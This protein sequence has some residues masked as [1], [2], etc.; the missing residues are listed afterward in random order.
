MAV[1]YES[2][3]ALVGPVREYSYDSRDTMLY[4]LGIGVGADATD[5]R[6]LAF[7]Y[8]KDL[9]VMPSMATVIAWDDTLLFE[10]GL[11]IVKIVHGE[12]RLKLERPLPVA[13]D[14]TSQ[15]RV[16][17]VF[18]KGEGRGCVIM[19]RQEITEVGKGLLATLDSVAFARGDGGVGGPGGS[20]EAL[21]PV[22][23]RAPDKV[24]S[25][26]TQDNQALFYRLCGD[27][28]PLHCD[29]DIAEAAGF[30]RPILHGLCTWGHAAH[31]VMRECLDYGVDDVR[32]I[33]ARFTAPV[34]PGETI[35]TEMWNGAAG[36]HFRAFVE[37]RDLK[38]LDYGLVT[39]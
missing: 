11:D 19:T 23:E 20:P 17:E 9:K 3:K 14:L 1:T 7:C 35:R 32:T 28:N 16:L 12:Q 39:S 34:F 24:M 2:L 18:D 21:P 29:L 36:V 5:R 25:A 13:A 6:Q 26:K 38:V 30:P 15:V 37:E 31:A 4:A 8:E 10:S 27:R 22:P 33:A